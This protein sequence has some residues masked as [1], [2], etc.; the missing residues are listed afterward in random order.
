MAPLAVL[1][2]HGHL[3]NGKASIIMHTNQ[4]ASPGAYIPHG[5]GCAHAPGEAT[6]DT[7]HYLRMLE[8]ISDWIT[9]A[10]EMHA[11]GGDE[12][13]LVG[14]LWLLQAELSTA[15]DF[16]PNVRPYQDASVLS[17]VIIESHRRSDT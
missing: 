14:E 11:S 8:R 17:C 10:R 5:R 4:A 2:S 9:R 1:A 16:C 12:R 6:L 13:R 3:A 15:L 7:C